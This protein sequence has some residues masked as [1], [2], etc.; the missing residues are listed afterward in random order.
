[1]TTKSA[2]HLSLADSSV[3]T[4]VRGWPSWAVVLLTVGLTFAGT[5]V[6]GLTTGALS[7]GLR[8]GF[9]LGVVL[10]ALLVRR[11][12]IFTAMI[13]PPLVL[14][15]GIVVGGWLFT[16]AGG[17]YGTALKIIG[18][19]PTMAIGTALAVII[20]LIRIVAQ[21]LR[22]SRDHAANAA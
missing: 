6:D 2:T 5:A 19:F 7:W 8:I 20:G 14:V 16:N 1:M 21:P 18:S 9:Y 12:S 4:S 15:F 22:N 13:Q 11:A 3:L 17:L 10:A